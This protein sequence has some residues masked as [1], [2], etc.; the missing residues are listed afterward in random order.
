MKPVYQGP[1]DM[2]TQQANENAEAA[3]EQEAFENTTDPIAAFNLFVK[4]HVETS[5]SQR[6]R[7]GYDPYIDADVMRKVIVH[8]V[9]AKNNE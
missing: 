3:A 6:Q 2:W 1:H 9:E 7:A 5:P 4:R 8:A